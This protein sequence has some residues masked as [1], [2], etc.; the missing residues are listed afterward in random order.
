MASIA[1]SN[2]RARPYIATEIFLGRPAHVMLRRHSTRPAFRQVRPSIFGPLQVRAAAEPQSASS[3]AVTS[4]PAPVMT[5]GVSASVQISNPSFNYQ[6]RS[7]W[8]GFT[9]PLVLAALGY[10]GWRFMVHLDVQQERSLRAASEE[11]YGKPTPNQAVPAQNSYGYD[12]ALARIRQSTCLDRAFQ[13]MRSR[14]DIRCLVDLERAL[15]QNSICREPILPGV[16]SSEEVEEIYRLYLRSTGGPPDFGK[17]LQLRDMLQLSQ[18]RA[19]AL[20]E[21]V[22]TDDSSFSI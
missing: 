5:S 8:S 3:P 4:L 2:A 18:V 1:F 22:Q 19:R 9:L 20:E 13:N 21:S 6:G 14:N 16:Y 17:L 11:L 10:L 12:M 7:P 15:E